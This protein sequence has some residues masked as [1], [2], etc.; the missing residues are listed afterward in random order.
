MLRS[1]MFLI[2]P[3]KS[4]FAG[5]AVLVA[6]AL[7]ASHARAV[8]LKVTPIPITITDG[9][10]ST[11]VEVANQSSEV[12]RLQAVALDW[13]QGPTG[14]DKVS[15]SSELLV[16]P[17][18]L[19]VKPGEALKVRVGTQGGYG[20]T[21]KSF[22][23]MF[24]E[25]PSNVT[26]ADG[27]EVVK[28]ITNVSVPVFLRPPGAAGKPVVE[29]LSATKDRIRFAIRNAGTAHAMVEKIRLEAKD[30][31]GRVLSSDEL[32]GWY[33][34]PGQVRPYDVELGK[35]LVCAGA[36]TI[37]V[38]AWSRESGQGSATLERPACAGP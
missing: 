37:V 10:T 25:I 32:T 16:F 13:S 1:P 31:A 2:R 4:F 3:R 23:V 33:V 11:M 5:C 18:M 9:A 6:G 14:E 17:S 38:T 21:E 28:V 26:P 20:A 36:R 7:L 30:D 29:A 12:L 35:K 22:R 15:P 24:S 27:Q 19:T 34:L 8:S